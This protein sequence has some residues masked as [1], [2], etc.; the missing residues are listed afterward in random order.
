MDINRKT[1]AE[2]VK[3]AY[4]LP[5]HKLITN[6]FPLRDV[7]TAYAS[8]ERGIRRTARWR[9]ILTP[10]KLSDRGQRLDVVAKDFEHCQHRHCQQRS[11]NAPQ[12]APKTQPQKDYYR[13]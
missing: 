2:A 9:S 3:L 5:F 13:I 12:P 10:E 11:R 7:T 6:R 1:F 8:F 4:S